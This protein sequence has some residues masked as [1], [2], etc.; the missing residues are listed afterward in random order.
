[1]FFFYIKVLYI[2][3]KHCLEIFKIIFSM[4][5]T[6][7]DENKSGEL[8]IIEFSGVNIY[9]VLMIQNQSRLEIILDKAKD[10]DEEL[11]LQRK[12]RLLMENVKNRLLTEYYFEAEDFDKLNLTA[13]KIQLSLKRKMTKD[14][15]PLRKSYYFDSKGS[16][17]FNV[18]QNNSERS[19]KNS[20]LKENIMNKFDLDIS[21]SP[22]GKHYNENQKL[23]S[24]F[25]IKE[26]KES[27]DNN[28]KEKII[29]DYKNDEDLYESESDFENEKEISIVKEKVMI[30]KNENEY[31]NDKEFENEKE[32]S[33]IKEKVVI[34]KNENEYENDKEFENESENEIESL[35]KGEKNIIE[36][37]NMINENENKNINKYKV[38]KNLDKKKKK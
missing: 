13:L 9:K 31:E 32:I 16:E 21:R 25:I 17:S 5:I 38:E 10:P 14:N 6:G 3:E 15:S 18:R 37:K 36:N 29:N 34:V 27:F 26:Q 24:N 20:D 12:E 30:V 35:F 23:L 33:I 28:K 2:P 4:K 8:K 22:Q 19:N 1:M 11:K 7:F